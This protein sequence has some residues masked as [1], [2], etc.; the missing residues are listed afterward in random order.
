MNRVLAVRYPDGSLCV[1]VSYA[2]FEEASMGCGAAVL[3]P[4][5]PDYD[6]YARHAVSVEEY[7]ER[8]C[9]DP[10]ESARLRAAFKRRYDRE[11]GPRR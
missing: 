6:H 5:D 2:D 3:R 10:A 8:H 4:G 11:H 7:T 1:P 9:D